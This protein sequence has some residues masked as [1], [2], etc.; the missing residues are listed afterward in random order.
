M[1]TTVND[2]EAEYFRGLAQATSKWSKKSSSSPLSRSTIL[3]GIYSAILEVP[4][5]RSVIQE[6]IDVE[7]IK[8]Q[9]ATLVSDALHR[10]KKSLKK[11]DVIREEDA[12]LLP[13][14]I[15]LE[16]SQPRND[17]IQQSR[18][19]DDVTYLEAAS[20]RLCA[21]GLK[22]G[23]ILRTFL[24]SYFPQQVGQAGATDPSHLFES[25]AAID[26][27]DLSLFY[28]PMD[29]LCQSV[30]AVTNGMD[31]K[32]KLEYLQQLM[33]DTKDGGHGIGELVAASQVIEQVAGEANETFDLA[34]AQSIL[35][36]H[37]QHT[38]SPVESSILI[39]MICKILNKGS[40][41]TTQWNIDYLLNTVC[42]VS[43][44]RAKGKG[45]T[46]L[47]PA[48]HSGLCSLVETIIKRH[49]LRLEGHFHLL[50]ATL[51]SLLQSLIMGSNTTSRAPD[52]ATDGAFG[53]PTWQQSAR[54]VSRLLELVCEPTVASVTRSQKPKLDS[55]TDA[56]KRS[57]G[58]YMYLVLMLYIKLQLEQNVPH[59]LREALEP[60]F[61][62]ILTVTAESSRKVMNDAMDASGRAI[63][64]ETYKK[65]QR[66]GK[67]K[68]I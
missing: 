41:S 22:I 21:K 52:G 6:H 31:G 60:G 7:R 29:L 8:E 56:A 57:A 9:S 39:E 35:T 44:Q 46:G 13:V 43:D 2:R 12:Q 47:S 14:F 34:L 53:S 38:H 4:A 24:D 37:L 45:A 5:S 51:Q 16:H 11:G 33:S 1:L 67:W 59:Q 50:V 23:W 55:A 66:F 63:F 19:S 3:N 27:T 15:A 54:Q 36:Q 17:L 20:R 25:H 49:R 48:I 64:R 42:A 28:A 58:Q 68:G 40:S 62:S 32:S 18:V 65:W 10:F 26:G 61:F 30:G